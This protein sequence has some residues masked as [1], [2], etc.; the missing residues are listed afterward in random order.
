MPDDPSE[1]GAEARGE[2]AEAAA[3]EPARPTSRDP[4][5][6]TADALVEQAEPAWDARLAPHLVVLRALLQGAA[7]GVLGSVTVLALVLAWEPVARPAEAIGICVFGGALAAAVG[8]L[9][10]LAEEV[11]RA[12][13]RRLRVAWSLLAGGA[14]PFAISLGMLWLVS[15]AEGRGPAGAVE[16]L[17]SMW[18]SALLNPGRLLVAMGLLALTTGAPLG[19]LSA[20]RLDAV[21]LRVRGRPWPVAV[22][23]VVTPL[24]AAAAFFVA[25]HVPELLF[26]QPSPPWSR[27][28][29]P[30]A[31][32]AAC[33]VTL[34]LG[35]ELGGRAY[36]AARAW[37]RARDARRT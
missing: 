29:R 35:L 16:E 4:V 25:L 26:A 3:P 10:T 1:E 2:A 12:L 17:T 32:Y 23:L 14:L 28:W 15:V 6:P 13:P 18:E 34:V 20:L 22:Q 30:L 8:G 33:A 36:R 11:A 27:A 24:A 19:V 7:T 31:T 9:V 37:Q 5:E 21:P